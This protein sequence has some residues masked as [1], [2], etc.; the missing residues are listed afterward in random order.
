MNLPSTEK[1]FTIPPSSSFASR[2]KRSL[3]RRGATLLES[4]KAPPELLA[5]PKADRPKGKGVRLPRRTPKGR[6]GG[7][8]KRP[9]SRSDPLQA[10][11]AL[12]EI[13]AL[14]ASISV[15]FRIFFMLRLRFFDVGAFLLLVGGRRR[16]NKKE[17]KT[18]SPYPT[19]QKPPTSFAGETN[20]IQRFV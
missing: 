18:G 3:L 7:L 11:Y 6:G 15:P 5:N 8:K 16:V 19:K 12:A 2:S 10:A 14:T 17:P 4:G 20:V 13:R 1:L 9:L